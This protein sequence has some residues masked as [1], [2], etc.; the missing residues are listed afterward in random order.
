M[1]DE[2]INKI[3]SDIPDYVEL[4]AISKTKPNEDIMKAYENGH[5]SF[6]ENKIQEAI[7]KWPQV[8]EQ[9]KEVKLHM[10]G[11]L[12]T[13]KVKFLIPLFDYL[14]SLDNLRLARKIS[15]EEEKKGKKIKIF[16]H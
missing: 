4:I 15:L 3:R 9:N 14:H 10:I 12:Q 8:K 16:I 13:N 1:I 6:G 7:E 11:K 5:R 2:N